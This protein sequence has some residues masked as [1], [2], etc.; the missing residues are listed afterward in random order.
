MS[1]IVGKEVLL[2]SPKATF[3]A[4]FGMLGTSDFYV[5]LGTSILR[6]ML[7]YFF[8]IAIGVILAVV[9]VYSGFAGMILSPLKSIIKATPVASFI[10]LAYMWLTKPQIPGVIAALIVIPIIWGNISEALMCVDKKMLECADVFGF[11]ILRRLKYI[12]IPHVKPYFAAGALTATGL[13]WKSGI[14]AEVLALPDASIG[15]MIYHAKMYLETVDL[16]AWT[17]AIILFSV[18]LEWGLIR[19][20]DRRKGGHNASHS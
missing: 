6:V 3:G 4:L 17:L 15:M 2:P 11:G 20:L 19:L 9:S 16:Y 8:G 18:I 10:I 7:G 14:A 13:A 5:A 12:Y 1:M